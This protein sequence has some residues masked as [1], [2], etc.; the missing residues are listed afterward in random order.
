MFSS[1]FVCLF[2]C[3]KLVILFVYTCFLLAK[4]SRITQKTTH[5][6]ITKFGGQVEPISNTLRWVCGYSECHSLFMELDAEL[7][8]SPPILQW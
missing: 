2:V 5:A 4:I 3:F 7:L 1:A 8:Q 6:I